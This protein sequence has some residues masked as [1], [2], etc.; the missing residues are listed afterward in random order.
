[1]AAF[2]EAAFPWI[3]LGIAVAVACTILHKRS[4][5]NQ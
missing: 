2:F 3:C 1:M 5:R 4:N